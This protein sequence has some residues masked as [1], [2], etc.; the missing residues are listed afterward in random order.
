[1]PKPSSYNRVLVCEGACNPDVREV[2]QLVELVEG[3]R[4]EARPYSRERTRALVHTVHQPID[5]YAKWDIDAG[6]C[7]R[8]RCAICKHVRRF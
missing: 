4:L 1:M 6:W 2:D 8:Y 7:T 5:D 3:G